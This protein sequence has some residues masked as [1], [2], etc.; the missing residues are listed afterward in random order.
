MPARALRTAVSVLLGLVFAA[1]LAAEAYA[2]HDCPHHHPGHAP[3]TES[4]GT[5]TLAS[6]A[7]GQALAADGVPLQAPPEGPCTC[8]GSCHATSVALDTALSAVLPSAPEADLGPSAPVPHDR[9]PR[10][11]A[12]LLPFANAP[13]LRA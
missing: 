8:V 3:R 5:D 4:G 6:P 12:Y 13:P 9:L 7:S 11:R 2:V 1:G 10:L